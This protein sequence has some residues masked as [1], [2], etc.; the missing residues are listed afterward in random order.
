MS[1]LSGQKYGLSQSVQ[2]YSKLGADEKVCTCSGLC[3]ASNINNNSNNSR[4]NHST[5][6][7]NNNNNSINTNNI[8][9]VVLTVIRRVILFMT[10]HNGVSVRR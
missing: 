3:S 4:N 1:C 9:V 10:R 7:G 2:I 6:N 5:N 8:V